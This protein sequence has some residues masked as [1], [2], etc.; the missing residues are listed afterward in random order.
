MHLLVSVRSVEEANLAGQMGVDLIDLKEPHL[1]SLG[2]TSP[3]IWR[4]V[5]GQWHTRTRVSLALGELPTAGSVELVPQETDS[6]KVGLAGCR[7]NASWRDDLSALFEQLP[8]GVQRVA[9]HY[10]DAHLAESPP[11]EDVLDMALQLNCQ[12]FLVDTFDK[13][14]GSVFNHMSTMSLKNLQ[15]RLHQAGLHFALAGSLRSHHLLSVAQIQPDIVAVRGAVCHRDRTAKVAADLL[16]SFRRQ[17]DDAL[18]VD[19]G[20]VL[21]R[22]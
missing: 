7:H 13:A 15:L 16:Q 1:G 5:V 22:R 3:A 18:K 12:T 19:T 4:S 11:W 9:V 8:R 14:A 10:A 20:E 17:L 6:V 2:A 21:S